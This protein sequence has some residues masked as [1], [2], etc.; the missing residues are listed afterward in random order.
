MDRSPPQRIPE[1]WGATTWSEA[2]ATVTLHPS[3]TFQTKT[4]FSRLSPTCFSQMIGRSCL[5]HLLKTWVSLEVEVSSSNLAKKEK[6]LN[7][8]R[9]KWGWEAPPRADLG[10]NWLWTNKIRTITIPQLV[11]E[12]SNLPTWNINLYKAEINCQIKCLEEDHKESLAKA[13]TLCTNWKS[14]SKIPRIPNLTRI[15]IAVFKEL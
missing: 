14:F 15:A 4:K 6:I 10:L 2:V 9:R 8:I 7:K 1:V 12:G 5:K 3:K 13:G 11:L